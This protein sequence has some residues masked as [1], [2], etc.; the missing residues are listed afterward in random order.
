MCHVRSPSTA[1]DSWSGFR[2]HAVIFH[3]VSVLPLKLQCLYPGAT[4]PPPPHLPWFSCL[5]CVCV[6]V[7]RA[8]Q[9]D[10]NVPPKKK[11]T[12]GIEQRGEEDEGERERMNEEKA[13]YQKTD[14]PPIHSGPTGTWRDNSLH[15][16]VTSAA[17]RGGALK[18][19][20]VCVHFCLL[21]CKQKAN[22]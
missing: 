5:L 21:T 6:C 18:H 11:N 16:R 13:Y 20:S 3:H 15:L 4:R 14:G 12:S 10:K 22:L 9:T 17:E 1:M 2:V 8:R 19:D 7:W